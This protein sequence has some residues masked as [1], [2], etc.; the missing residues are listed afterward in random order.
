M[1]APFPIERAVVRAGYDT[2]AALK[3]A[4]DAELRQ[5]PGLRELR[6]AQLRAAL[7]GIASSM[8][9]KG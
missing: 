9:G 3:L 5:I 2:H 7:H 6:L 8:G 4:T 1:G